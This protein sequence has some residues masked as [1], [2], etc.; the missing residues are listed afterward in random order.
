[1][2]FWAAARVLSEAGLG[3]SHLEEFGL[4]FQTDTGTL[5][6]SW[7]RDKKAESCTQFRPMRPLQTGSQCPPSCS[8]D[9]LFMM[10][11][12]WA[13]EGLGQ[14]LPQPLMTSAFCWNVPPRLG[15]W[16]LCPVPVSACPSLSL[17]LFLPTALIFLEKSTGSLGYHYWPLCVPN[18]L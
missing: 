17:N 12:L 11:A 9:L 8:I 13:P 18:A 5:C 1:M 3:H 6:T 15:V 2:G 4:K 10:S 14:T 16:T 7:Q